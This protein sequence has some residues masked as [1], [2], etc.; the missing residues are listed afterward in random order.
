MRFAVLL[1]CLTCLNS[2]GRSKSDSVVKREGNPDYFRVGGESEE[3]M[4][5]AIAQ[6]RQEIGTFIDALA[7]PKSSYTHLS[8]KKPFPYQDGN[9]TAH[10]HI[11]LTEVSFR[12]GKF[13]GRVGNDPVD[14]KDLKL[15][16]E[17]ELAKEEASDW[18]IIDDGFLIGGYTILAL[19]DAMPPDEQKEF[20]EQFP[21][22][23]R[24]K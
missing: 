8:V 10:E 3:K 14:V 1:V 5:E 21:Y 15:G 12:D 20:D 13:Y 23:T 24:A 2:C 19:R 9:A 22:K 7:N 4:N 17:V 6:S 16:D 11:W 18:M